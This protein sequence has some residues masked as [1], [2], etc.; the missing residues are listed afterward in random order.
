MIHFYLIIT[1]MI[2]SLV[3]VRFFLSALFMDRVDRCGGGCLRSISPY[4]YR[5]E[6]H[7]RMAIPIR[8]DLTITSQRTMDTAEAG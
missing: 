5:Y 8:D 7:N 3:V 4:S 1:E 2:H 6:Y